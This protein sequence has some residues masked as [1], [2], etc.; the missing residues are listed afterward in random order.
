MSVGDKEKVLVESIRKRG[1]LLI[2]FSGGVDSSLLAG[3]AREILGDRCRAVLLESPVVPG[4]AV[5]EAK[6]TAGILGITLEVVPVPLMEDKTFLA[7]PPDRCY[8]CKKAS[9]R[10]LK[11]RAG[12]LGFAWVADGINASDLGEHRPGILASS[13]EGIL[14]P[15]IEA[16]ITKADIRAIARVRG[17]PF[18]DRPS[19]ACL[20]SRIPY[21]DGIT[22]VKLGMIEAAENYLRERGFTQARVR[23][24][25]PV[26]RIE[27]V[28]GE[29]DRL[30]K[31]RREVQ[32]RLR[33]A[34]FRYVTADLAGYRSGS[35]DEVL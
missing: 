6:E 28:P 13:E 4:V 7:N 29:M 26:A 34:G 14:H 2:A 33:A 31:E 25:G 19:A 23:L 30:W 9:A 21:G 8:I 5:Q 12:E 27:V 15:F 22:P 3:I 18:W 35:M 20:S 24:H 11:K 32:A 16:G 1:S 17:Y 10:I